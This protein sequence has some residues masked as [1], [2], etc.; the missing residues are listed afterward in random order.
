VLYD[1]LAT[2]TQCKVVDGTLVMLVVKY[3]H[4]PKQNLNKI[5][6]L[7]TKFKFG[8]KTNLTSLDLAARY[9]VKSVRNIVITTYLSFAY[10]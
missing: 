5:Q 1:V 6:I 7:E 10:H 8:K 4:R 9:L 3:Y 2:I